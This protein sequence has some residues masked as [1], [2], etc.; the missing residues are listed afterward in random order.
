MRSLVV[1]EVSSYTLSCDESGWS[2]HN[3]VVK[4]STFGGK[5]R[6]IE[7]A[8][9]GSYTHAYQELAL[10]PPAG[11]VYKVSGEFYPLAAGDCDG[12]VAVKWCS[13]S[14]VILPG[15]YDAEFYVTGGS[16][17]GLAPSPTLKDAWEPFVAH[18]TSTSAVATLYIIQE[19]TVC[20]RF[21]L[22]Y[23]PSASN[24]RM[25]P[26]CFV[27]DAQLY[28]AVPSGGGSEQLHIIVR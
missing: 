18:F 24:Q 9:A 10:S 3:A 5:D 14:L 4:C 12:S 25:G 26:I 19:S 23:L 16:Y 28:R 6:A 2:T 27:T 15:K 7:V 22:Q 21:L 8:D 11:Q 13:P 20:M 17:V 1:E